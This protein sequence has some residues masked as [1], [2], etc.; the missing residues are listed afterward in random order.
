[1]DKDDVGLM[2][3][4]RRRFAELRGEFEQWKPALQELNEYILPWS[5]RYLFSDKDIPGIRRGE[6]IYNPAVFNAVKTAASGLHG[7][8]TSPSR[9]WFELMVPDK[10]LM[11]QVDVKEWTHNLQEQKRALLAK[12]NFYSEIQRL[13][14]E[15][16]SYSTGVMLMEKSDDTGV[17]FRTLTCGEYY[18]ANGANLRVNTLYRRFKM[19]SARMREEYGEENMSRQ[20]RE[21]LRNDRYEVAFDI[22]QAIQPYGMFDGKS[23]KR[24]KFESVHFEDGCDEG[25][26]LRKSGYRAQ[27]FVAVRWDTIGDDVYGYGPGHMCLADV[28]QLQT[29]ERCYVNALNW[30][31][32]PAWVVSEDVKNKMARGDIRPGAIVAATSEEAKSLMRPLFQPA[33]DFNNTRLKIQDIEARIKSTFY[34]DL[35]MMVQGRQRE[36]TATE[37]QQLIEEKA[38][39]LGPVFETFL[40]DIFDPI[41]EFVYDVMQNDLAIIPPAPDAMAGRELEIEY[42]SLLAQAQ[43]Q[44][45]LSNLTHFMQIAGQVVQMFPAAADKLNPDEMVDALY[46]TSP[47]DPEIV[48]S[49]E[50]VAEIRRRQQQAMRQQ[51]AAGAIPAMAGAAKDLSQAQ[52]TSDNA[53]GALMGMRGEG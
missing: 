5:G 28:R 32:D 42:V 41:L 15:A 4:Y 39:V 18:I 23:H 27:P 33:F 25:K 11:E 37:V 26:F 49:D 16:L 47:V 48:R 7:G 9:P 31:A 6:N 14:S 10:R 46:R 29:Q 19:T 22:V 34:N 20:A 44:A 2:K 13:Y 40:S 12:S 50:E 30:V 8:L 43:K 24:W 38:T 45:G 35:F 17:R 21:C 1:V 52:P 51:Q 3:K 53:L 36:M